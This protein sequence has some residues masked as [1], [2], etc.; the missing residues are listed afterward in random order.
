MT[1]ANGSNA[2]DRVNLTRTLSTPTE[3]HAVRD[4]QGPYEMLGCTPVPV[5]FKRLLQL[6]LRGIDPA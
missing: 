1:M 2:G 3:L 4:A 6:V 5:A